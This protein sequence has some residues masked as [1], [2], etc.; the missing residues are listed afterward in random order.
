MNK[1]QASHHEHVSY[2]VDQLQPAEGLCICVQLQTQPS[3]EEVGRP[4]VG[5]AQRGHH[6]KLLAQTDQ[7]LHAASIEHLAA[8]GY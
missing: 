5:Q 7:G 8:Q 4:V 6:L 3:Q 1:V 2:L